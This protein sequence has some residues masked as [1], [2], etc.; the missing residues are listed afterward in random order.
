MATYYS[1][2][3]NFPKFGSFVRAVIGLPYVP[4]ERLE[5]A[6]RI[7]QKLG[8]DNTEKRK[9]FCK[10]MLDYLRRTW[11]DGVIPREV[12]NMYEHSGVAT[13][14]HAEGYNF[15]MGAKH[16]IAKHP[17]PYTLVDEIR[18]QLN[19]ATDT[20]L[21]DSA[22]SKR[23]KTNPH[24]QQLLKRRKDLMKDLKKRNIDLEMFIVSISAISLK[25]DA[26]VRDDNDPDPLGVDTDSGDNYSD[27]EIEI[28]IVPT[29]PSP[30]EPAKPRPPPA[31]TATAHP[32]RYRKGK[33]KKQKAAP[34]TRESIMHIASQDDDETSAPSLVGDDLRQFRRNLREETTGSRSVISALSAAAV[35]SAGLTLMSRFHSSASARRTPRRT[36]SGRASRRPS[37]GRTPRR[38]SKGRTPRRTS[39][40]RIPSY[41]EAAQRVENSEETFEDISV[42]DSNEAEARLK[43][44]GF[45]VS[46]TQPST[47]GD[48]NCMLYALWD[49]LQRCR[50]PI[51]NSLSSP[52]HLRLLVCSKLKDQLASDKIFWVEAVS[53][54]TWLQSMRTD[55]VWC[56]EV[57]LQLA[58]NIL[59]KNVIIIP[60]SPS[61]AHHSGMY[62]TL[63]S[64]QGGVG[65]PLYMLYFEEWRTA[66]HYQS[67]EPDPTVS[68]NKVLS[69]FKWLTRSF[70]S[71]YQHS[72]SYFESTQP[73]QD[74]T[75]APSSDHEVL[76]PPPAPPVQVDSADYMLQSTRQRLESAENCSSSQ[77]ISLVASRSV[78][79]VSIP[80]S[81]L[82]NE[83]NCDHVCV[84]GKHF[85]SSKWDAWAAAND[86]AN[87]TCE[88]CGMRM[89][90]ARGI[91]KQQR[92]QFHILRRC[93]KYKQ[94]FGQ[95]SE[96]EVSQASQGPTER[97]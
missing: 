70:S 50:H 58:C 72:P 68:N 4:L 66:G 79:N 51:L 61:S 48:G 24:T 34:N 6:F 40:S 77:D 83:Q 47:K 26:R 69:H 7:L 84:Y 74:C 19:E 23:K 10:I 31:A 92:L 76:C 44:L 22:T 14:N 73:S 3:K 86:T 28:D 42:A 54:D 67:I 49:Q 1:D 2:S 30:A 29:E 46:S 35:A 60:L 65:D 43:Q 5:E 71:S 90:A 39:A 18:T 11:L 63:R 32:S 27:V 93:Q 82:C 41:P 45:K 91:P 13:N 85:D 53:P 64:T 12:W 52:H 37:E 75:P 16:K 95:N 21:A 87:G 56:D 62:S 94:L 9:K 33:K 25:H 89:G 81:I 36:S 8:R 15:K 17:N 88:F 97:S 59:N 96:M 20:V 78:V 55:K 57:F 80:S 38:T